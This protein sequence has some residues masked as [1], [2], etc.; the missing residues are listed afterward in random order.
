MLTV[1]AVVIIAIGVLG[2]VGVCA[3]FGAMLKGGYEGKQ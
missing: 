1:I 2:G 3:A